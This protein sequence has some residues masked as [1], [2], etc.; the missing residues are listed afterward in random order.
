[1]INREQIENVKATLRNL[2]Q[3][4]HEQQEDMLAY[5]LHMAEVEAEDVLS[6]RWTRGSAVEAFSPA[7]I[8]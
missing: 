1:M 8:Q 2:K 3:V 7:P 4:A 6:G 5:L